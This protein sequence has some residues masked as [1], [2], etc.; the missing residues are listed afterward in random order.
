M[1]RPNGDA[2]LGQRLGADP[3]SVVFAIQAH[4]GRAL[5]VVADGH[6]PRA[7]A[8][9]AVLLVL[10]IG[11]ATGIERYSGLFRAPGTADLRFG[12]RGAVDRS[13]PVFRIGAIHDYPLDG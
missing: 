6:M 12:V 9:R 10:L 3:A 4:E 2:K 5:D 7:A 11:A 13:Q 8:D 1:Q